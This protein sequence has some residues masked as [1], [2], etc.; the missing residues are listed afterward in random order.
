LTQKFPYL[1]TQ[2]QILA[3]FWDHNN[4]KNETKLLSHNTWQKL[5]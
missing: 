4:K 3:R 5:W 1:L 2:T